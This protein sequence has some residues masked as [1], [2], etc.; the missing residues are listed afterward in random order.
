MRDVGRSAVQK[1]ELLL[2]MAREHRSRRTRRQ[3]G[4][5]GLVDA[6]YWRTLSV[7]GCPPPI[8]HRAR[9]PVAGPTRRCP[10]APPAIDHVPTAVLIRPPRNRTLL[11]N[12]GL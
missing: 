11:I 1:T 4:V 8:K 5:L 12:P 3:Q 2:R 6:W 9:P 10:K 7:L